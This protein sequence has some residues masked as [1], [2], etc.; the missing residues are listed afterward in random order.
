[1]GT[2]TVK[3]LADL[4]G[5]SVRTLHHYE[6]VGLLHPARRDNG[7]RA[8]AQTDVERLQQV[9]L[10]RA[11]GMQL[12]DIRALLDA[13]DFDVR[14]ALE[15][16]LAA[17][18]HQRE[19]LERLIATVRKTI[20]SLEGEATMTDKERF[21]GLKRKAIDENER[22]HGAE[23]RARYGDAAADAANERL[24]AMDEATWNDMNAL[25]GAIIDQLRVAMAAN[26]HAGPDATLLCEMHARW[27]ALHWGEGAYTPAA[28]LGLAHG[29]LAD[30]RF[31]EYYDSRA[32]TGATEFLVAALEAYLG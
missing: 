32:G 20:C 21:E 16:H 18:E 8:Y 7:Y 13:P 14:Q 2:Y 4:S 27:I 19:E 6:D 5:V 24:L 29:Y 31:V 25:E 10:F 28:H 3:Q 12:E 30:A 22:R 9:L 1:M 15:G 17:L 26:D 11:C 23:V